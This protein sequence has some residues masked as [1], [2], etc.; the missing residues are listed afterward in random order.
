[1]Q[2]V[3]QSFFSIVF[4]VFSIPFLEAM[5]L[6]RAKW[7]LSFSAAG[8]LTPF[9]LGAMEGLREVGILQDN[10]PLAGASGGALAAVCAAANVPS[11]E[12]LA[13][14]TRI[15]FLCEKEGTFGTL[16][17]ALDQ[18]LEETIPIDIAGQLNARKG[19][20]TV[21]YQQVF[22]S[23][24]SCMVSSFMDKEDVCECL[25]ASCNIP[26]YSYSPRKRIGVSVR[27]GYGIDGFFATPLHRVGCPP[28]PTDE[29]SNYI[30]IS[31]FTTFEGM[32][33]GNNIPIISPADC[34]TMTSHTIDA[35]GSIDI[36]AARFAN[37]ITP[38]ERI[39]L[40]LAPPSEAFRARAAKATEGQISSIAD[41]YHALFHQGKLA[42]AIF[43]AS[44][45][46]LQ[47]ATDEKRK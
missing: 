21:A 11:A 42:T 4:A 26:F 3:K 15:S 47:E 16:G 8:L 46:H 20:V 17:R 43:V 31:P 19:S 22:P 12:L 24:K 30:M 32:N 44:N 27:D 34:Q 33:T 41:V 1:M 28:I 13:I 6:N 5:L 35:S 7:G 38:L 14:T 29:A 25:R 36:H 10:T 2:S 18:A 37:S 9:H 45:E 40:A 39:S 23:F